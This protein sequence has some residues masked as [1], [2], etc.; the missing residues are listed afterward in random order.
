MLENNQ[1]PLFEHR[2]FNPL[3]IRTRKINFQ[4]DSSIPRLW[5]NNSLVMTH[6]FNGMNLFIPG[7]EALM[8]RVIR[9]QLPNIQD[10]DLKQQ[11]RGL[12]AQEISH[13]LT[14]DKY[15]HILRCQGYKFAGYLRFSDFVFNEVMEKG[16]STKVCLAT[17]AGFEH[18]TGI[19][20]NLVLNQNV[21]KNATPIMKD[22][23]EWHAAEEVEHENLVFEVL[24]TVDSNY[25]L[26]ILGL[27][28]GAMVLIV[29]TVVGMLV[30]GLQEPGLA[31]RQTLVDLYRLFFKENKLVSCGFLNFCRY[32]QFKNSPSH[33]NSILLAEQVLAVK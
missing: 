5:L 31:S 21:M 22:L 10:Y 26:R 6:F 16:L 17:G 27:F 15:N 3:K 9:K 7:F 19:L 1:K 14:H 32:F 18:L 29:F 11:I 28:L 25:F 33:L 8:V 13:S 20:T 2:P 4:F 24:Q 12:I 30:L 23:W